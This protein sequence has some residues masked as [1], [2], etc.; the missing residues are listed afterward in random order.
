MRSW[1]LLVRV[2]PRIEIRNDV[3]ISFGGPV[4]YL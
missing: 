2:A 4:K 3:A 1:P